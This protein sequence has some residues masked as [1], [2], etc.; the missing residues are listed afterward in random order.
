MFRLYHRELVRFVARIVGSPD[1]AEEIA[2]ETYLRVSRRGPLAAA[3]DHPKTYLFAAARNTAMD[4]AARQRPSWHECDQVE[5]VADGE[6]L[7]DAVVH[8]RR[9]LARMAEAL[10]ELP[11][12]CRR[13]FV[14]NKLHG[15]GHAAIARDL[16]VSVSM[17]EKHIMRAMAHCRDRLREEEA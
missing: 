8:H 1:T 14:L 16:G 11:A 17:V 5:A 6:P 13:A 10:N 3:I 4:H 2:Q 9:R 15:L 7:A 12:P